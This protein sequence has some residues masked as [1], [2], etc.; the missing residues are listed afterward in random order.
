MLIL[1]LAVQGV[2]GFSPSV[3]LAFKAG[4]TILVSPTEIPAPLAG[5]TTALVYPDGR[6][7]DGAFLAPGSKLGRA[8]LSVQSAD[9]NI[10]RVVRD[11]GGQG[12]LHK[13][14]RQTNQFEVLTQ[15]ATEQNQ[16]LRA[17]GFPARPTFEQLFTLTVGQLPSRRP[18][19][20]TKAAADQP[21]KPPT[22]QR[23]RSA[24]D[25]YANE[26]TP[27]DTGPSVEK[28]AALE[29]ELAIAKEV[30]QIQF[31]MDGVQADAFKAEQR[32]RAFEE[33][34]AKAESARAELLKAPTPQSLGLPDDIVERVRRSG[35]EKKRRDEAL[36]RLER[37]RAD[38]GLGEDEPRVPPVWKDMRFLAA[39]LAGF[40]LLVAGAVFEGMGRFLAL[41]AIPAF[42]FAG[43]LVLRFIEELQYRSREAAKREVFEVRRKKLEDEFVLAASI[44]QTAL[45]KVEANTADEFVTLMARR[46]ELEPAVG[47]LELEFADFE[48]DPETVGLADTVVRLKA[49]H[50]EMNQKLLDLS[51]GYARETREIERE[52]H[53]MRESLSGKV[54]AS[55]VSGEF[56]AVQTGPH[57]TFDDPCPAAMQLACEIFNADMATLWGVM[58]D[59]CV[60]YLVA[61]TDKR[62]HGVDLDVHGRATVQ[63]PGR[64]V[65]AGE[66]PAKDLDLL[67]VA[68]RLTIAEKAGAQTKLPV[69]IEDAF[70]GVIDASKQS[71]FARMLKHIGTL[72][73]VLHV[74]GASQTPPAA[75][76]TLA[77]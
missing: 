12:T 70:G 41:L 21:G 51:G 56:A 59:R 68:L 48:S 57:E 60:Q 19:A 16:A 9:Q 2:R 44:V 3:R 65:V 62:Y 71:L 10:W 29:K 38:A 50:E 74:I 42:T 61:L 28:L 30:A 14:D 72:T 24:F 67:Y 25:Q 4:Y 49:E 11:L 64:S 18:R 27:A 76:A 55:S 52:L 54:P 40:L 6:G 53:R 58:R 32:L 77:V 46:A 45:D 73:Q 33:L 36:A 5:L 17:A 43:L 35:D 63:A 69:L 75:D 23:V 47:A 15:E 37:E 1:E 22:G 31:R 20:S 8:G 39:L 13:L 34:K 66:L 26:L 7:G